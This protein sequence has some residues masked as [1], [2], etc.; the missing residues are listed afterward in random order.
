MR[1]PR[2]ALELVGDPRTGIADDTT[3][4]PLG[5]PTAEFVHQNTSN[6]VSWYRYAVAGKDVLPFMH[7]DPRLSEH[8]KNM[9]YLLRAAR[10]DM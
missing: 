7:M 5:A 4:A 1:A 2:R 10:P 6:L 8:S 9:M 3:T